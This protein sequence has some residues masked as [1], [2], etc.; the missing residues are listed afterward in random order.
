MI[1]S[2]VDFPEPFNPS[3]PILAG[4]KT[5]ADIAQ[6]NAL[7]RHNLANPVHGVNELSHLLPVLN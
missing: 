4:K 5:Q 7:G 2:K 6:D 1:F 3:T